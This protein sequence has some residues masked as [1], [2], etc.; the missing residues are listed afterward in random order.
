MNP[1]DK[2]K[3]ILKQASN[4]QIVLDRLPNK[5]TSL[6]KGKALRNR[7]YL[8]TDKTHATILKQTEVEKHVIQRGKSEQR[9]YLKTDHCSENDEE[10]KKIQ[11]VLAKKEPVVPLIATEVIQIG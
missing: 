7:R 4:L 11:A 5:E 9:R 10:E 8:S 2:F 1:E 6:Y 3:M